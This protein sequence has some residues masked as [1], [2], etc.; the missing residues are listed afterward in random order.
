MLRVSKPDS[1]HKH[2][3]FSHSACFLC[4]GDKL[5]DRPDIQ[6]LRAG[7]PNNATHAGRRKHKGEWLVVIAYW[8][9]DSLSSRYSPYTINAMSMQ[10]FAKES[11][12]IPAAASYALLGGPHTY[13]EA[14]RI[15]NQ[16]ARKLDRE[17]GYS[18]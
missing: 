3:K 6:E 18:S 10:A 4:H 17:D 13:V 8:A 15:A 1:R 5:L 11:R 7:E 12:R 2:R 14:K 9:L 16:L